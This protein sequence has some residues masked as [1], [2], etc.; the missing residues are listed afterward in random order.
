M[1]SDQP[2]S[3]SVKQPKNSFQDGHPANKINKIGVDNYLI[4]ITL[5]I[6]G[7]IAALLSWICKSNY[8]ELLHNDILLTLSYSDVNYSDPTVTHS[9]PTHFPLFSPTSP[10]LSLAI[11]YVK[12]SLVTFQ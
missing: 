2:G 12:F 7:N 11:S 10:G 1:E 3:G 5:L 8:K 9:N 6:N 4:M